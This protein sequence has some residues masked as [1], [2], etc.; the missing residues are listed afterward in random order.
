MLYALDRLWKRGNRPQSLHKRRGMM[1]ASPCGARYGPA[2]RLSFGPFLMLA[3]VLVA[4]ALPARADRAGVFDYYVLALSWSPGWCAAD[5]DREDAAQCE[6]GRKVDFL[7]HGLWPQYERGWPENCTTDA[8]NPSRAQ[9][10][11]MDDIMPSGD[12]AFYQWQ[13]H[14]RCSGLSGADYYR[15]ARAAWDSITLPEIFVD[16]DRDILIPPALVEQ[17][18][19]EA[20]P[21]FGPDAITVTC[22][23]EALQE[24]RIC[25]TRDL[26]PRNCAADIRRDC[27]RPTVLMPAVR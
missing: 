19:I 26:Q 8:R 21:G 16:L 2:M 20:N 22:R 27:S 13:K 12:L 3:A 5:A 4:T 25:M 6:P 15:E 7:M 23:G 14:G 1:R 9:S 10:R 18:F 24:V 17:A 11:A